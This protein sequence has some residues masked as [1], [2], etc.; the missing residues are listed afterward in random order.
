[1]LKKLI[2]IARFDHWI[3]QLFILP[4]SMI[5][6]LLLKEKYNIEIIK[7]IILC[8][9]S[10]SF[11][12]SAN[13]VINEYLD[14]EFDKYHPIKNKRPLVESNLKREYI[15][16]EYFILVGIG[17][18]LATM[19]SKIVLLLEIILLG[20]GILYNVKPFRLKE[21]AYIDVLIESV[22]NALRFLIGW[23]TITSL[24][25]PPVSIVFGY[26]MA[27]AY[28]MS[29]KRLAEY[30]M[31]H[32][33]TIASNYRKSFKYYNEK[34]LMV[35]SMFLALMSVFFLGIFLIKYKIEFLIS[36]PFLIGLFCYYFGISFK[37]DSAVQRPE[38]LYKE[39]EL[40]AY[41]LIISILFVVLLYV[42]IPML[43]SFTSIDLVP[44]VK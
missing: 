15:Y 22:N 34:R 13:Y 30:K 39:K 37:E 25:Y 33:K 41:L 20:M 1:M 12:A 36:I 5:A 19:I 27:G 10:T 11:I 16:I 9:F 6:I 18:A 28:L 43:D 38:K 40:I 7:S 23:F 35:Y 21:I 29:V 4:G 24:F 44:I 17:I 14:A 42:R 2:K 8:F 26:W 32:D 31:I 3:K